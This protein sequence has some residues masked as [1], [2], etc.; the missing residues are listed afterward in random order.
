VLIGRVAHHPV[1]LEQAV[2]EPCTTCRMLLGEPAVHDEHVGHDEQ[3]AVGG[4]H[5]RLCRRCRDHL[6]HLGL[7]GHAAGQTVAAGLQVAQEQVAGAEPVLRVHEVQPVGVRRGVEAAERVDLQARFLR[8]V[9]DEEVHLGELRGRE[10][11][12]FQLVDPL[13][14]AAHDDAVGAAREA[15]L[16]GH[17][18]VQLPA[19]GREH[20]HRRHRRGDAPLVQ[21]G[22]VLVLADREPHLEAVVL[23]EERLLGRLEAAVGGDEP[24]VARVFAD[25][26]RDDVVAELDGA[27]GRQRRDLDLDLLDLR[28]S[29]SSPPPSPG[30][31]DLA[32]AAPSM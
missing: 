29:S 31:R 11:L 3:V 9:A 12:P 7:P 17:H 14:V 23:E 8:E 28:P 15:D 24:G 20:V 6:R 22:P 30:Q 32:E 1:A 18:G 21:L 25:L 2:H 5:V 26:D 10:R 13:D 16:R 19:V 27:G 4:Q